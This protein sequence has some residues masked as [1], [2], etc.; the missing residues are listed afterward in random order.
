MSITNITK[1]TTSYTNVTKASHGEI[2]ST[3][4]NIW[5]AESRTWGA[6]ASLLTNSSK[7]SSTLTNTV[8]P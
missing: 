7:Q 8:K 4:S 5:S 6:M 1:P 3:A 2:W